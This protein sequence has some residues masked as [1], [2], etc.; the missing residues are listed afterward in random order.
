VTG[1]IVKD[2]LVRCGDIVES[3]QR[4]VIVERA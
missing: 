1:G 3:N 2:V 4:M